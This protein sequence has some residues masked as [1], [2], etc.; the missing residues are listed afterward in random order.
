VESDPRSTFSIDVDTAS[1]SMVRRML[2]EGQRPPVGAVRIEEMLNYF[3]YAYPEP[4]A[5]QPFSVVSELSAAPWQPKH[6]LLRLG[7]KARHI[8]TSQ[9]PASNLVFLVDVSGSM[10]PEDKLPLLQRGLVLLAQQLRATDRVS[11]VVYAGASGV[12]LPSTP[13]DRRK[14]ITA[15]LDRL[16]AGGSTNGASGIQLAY[17]QARAGFIEGGINRVILATDGDFNVG[18]T[19]H[20]ELVDLITRQAKTGV[21]LSVLG[22][23]RGNYKDDTL[24]QLADKGNGNYAYVDSLAEA[25]K[26][27][28]EQASGTLHTVAKD[29]KIQVEFNPA[30]VAGFR[31]IGYENRK[32][33]HGDFNDD[34]KDAGEI[35]ADHTVTALYEIVPVGTELPGA[36][37]D[38][39]TYQRPTEPTAR[40]AT[41]ELLTVNLRYKPPSGDQSRRLTHIVADTAESF[42]RAS[43][44]FRFASSVATF[45][46]ALRGSEHRGRAAAMRAAPN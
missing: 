27:L 25:R 23:G 12:V 26:V 24:E 19:S 3:S 42:A 45:A 10:Q 36:K 8:D 1:Y 30:R 29:V 11:L 20:S 13:G 35:G 39:L 7:I 17:A 40:A 15:A 37:V 41:G 28:V 9:R 5:D 34:R 14:E 18:L 31:L 22:V 38:A 6:K 21:F 43:R 16:A 44:D 32:L 2:R 46:M 33:A 4:E